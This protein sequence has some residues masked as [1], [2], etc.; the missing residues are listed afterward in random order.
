MMPVYVTT[1][2]CTRNR[3]HHRNKGECHQIHALLQ[4]AL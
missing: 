1:A 2:R 3:H 4:S